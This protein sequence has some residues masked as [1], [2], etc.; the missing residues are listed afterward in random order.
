MF[1]GL[2][3]EFLGV[4]RGLIFDDLLSRGG[5][6]APPGTRATSE[7]LLGVMPADAG[8]GFVFLWLS[9]AK[10]ER[11]LQF[12]LNSKSSRFGTTATS[13]HKLLRMMPE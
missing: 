10:E 1:R 13:N 6:A 12:F 9:V 8:W 11:E 2:I 5:T 3:F 4:V 7:L